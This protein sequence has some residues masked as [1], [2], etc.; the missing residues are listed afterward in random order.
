MNE[1]RYE[2]WVQS[3]PTRMARCLRT[4]GHRLQAIR[5]AREHRNMY[6]WIVTI[7]DT[8]AA[9]GAVIIQWS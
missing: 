5:W 7:I 3:H 4:M 8:G 2:I 9:G 1:K 6:G